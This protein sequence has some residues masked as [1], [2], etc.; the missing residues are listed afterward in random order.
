MADI[1]VMYKGRTE[2]LDY[3]TLFPQER[4]AAIGITE[5]TEI[6]AATVTEAQVKTALAQHFDVGRDEF[7]DHFV[8]LNSKTNTITIRPDT[9]FGS[10]L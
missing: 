5:G 8:E 9:P 4:L 10:A 6:S 7:A 2:D 1:H 3:G